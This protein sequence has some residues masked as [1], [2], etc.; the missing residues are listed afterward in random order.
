MQCGT[1]TPRKDKLLKLAV[2]YKSYHDLTFSPSDTAFQFILRQIFQVL[3]IQIGT[4][5]TSVETC[6]KQKPSTNPR[7]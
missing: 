1:S 5:L 3:Q 7:H 2:A 6:V 4:Y